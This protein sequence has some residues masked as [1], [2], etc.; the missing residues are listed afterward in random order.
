M[1]TTETTKKKRKLVLVVMVK[2]EIKV[3][4]NQL[5]NTLKPPLNTLP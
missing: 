1:K 5:L 2:S 3:D 4:I